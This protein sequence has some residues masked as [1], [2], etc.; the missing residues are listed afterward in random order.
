[1][2]SILT[3]LTCIL[4]ALASFAYARYHYVDVHSATVS[5]P[6]KSSQKVQ[7]TDPF[8][9]QSLFGN[10]VKDEW[11]FAI[12]VPAILLVGGLIVST[13]R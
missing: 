13:R 6:F 9:N 2:K 10:W 3:F 8:L 1:M 7:M 5:N 4:L 12:A 11:V